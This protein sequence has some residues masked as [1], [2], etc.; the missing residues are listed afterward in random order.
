MP[1]ALIS[2]SV[3]TFGSA[4]SALMTVTFCPLC[5]NF[6]SPGP[7]EYFS[8]ETEA[9]VP[10]P[11]RRA[12][13]T[14]IGGL[15]LVAKPSAQ[16]YPQDVRL[17]YAARSRRQDDGRRHAARAQRL[18]DAAIATIASA[19]RWPQRRRHRDDVD[20]GRRGLA[21]R[22]RPHARLR[23]AP[24]AGRR[25][26]G[27]RP[28]T[29]AASTSAQMMTTVIGATLCEGFGAK[30]LAHQTPLTSPAAPRWR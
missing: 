30:D 11:R 16:Q 15:F 20:L 28:S 19:G 18:D 1:C 6:S 17:I 5:S 21:K 9:S 12:A 25:P 23:L 4:W 14:N 10:R 24:A 13:K 7:R 27:R 3:R 8:T 2:R 26:Y 22:H 29:L